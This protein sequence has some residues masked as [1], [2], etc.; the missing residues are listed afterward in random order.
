MGFFRRLSGKT[1]AGAAVEA[2]DVQRE[3]AFQSAGDVGVAGQQ[4]GALLDPFAQLG[5]QGLDQAGFLTD[6]TA[7]FD[8]LQGNPLF[9]ASLENAN[10]VT[11][12]SAASRGRLSSGD[13]AM[14]LSRNFLLAAQPLI[15]QQKQS[16]T[17][18]IN[19]GLDVAG[20][21]GGILTGTAADVA[22]L[23]TGGAAAQAGGI[24]GAENARSAGLQNI[25]D[26]GAQI[27]APGDV[28]GASAAAAA[29]DPRLKENIKKVGEQSGFNIYTWDWNK[30]AEVLGLKGSSKGVMADEVKLVRPEAIAFKLGFMHV[31]Y[32]MIGVDRGSSI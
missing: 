32:N 22:N 18:L 21:Q 7:Q 5:Q 10:R 27:L 8:F 9:Q 11:Q 1:A 31:D 13:T 3:Q 14:D 19:A 23:Q 15:G 20:Q 17:G 25:L 28:E 4:A 30:V 6:P 2:G 16:I 29:S 24:V 12:Q 26:I